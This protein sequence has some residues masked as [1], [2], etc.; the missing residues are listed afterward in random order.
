[1]RPVVEMA[2]TTFR[3]YQLRLIGT[4]NASL[5][6]AQ[7][8]SWI[9]RVVVTQSTGDTGAFIGAGATADFD[10]P[11]AAVP[12]NGFE[13]PLGGVSNV[14][15]LEPGQHLVAVGTTDPAQDPTRVS[16]S[17]SA[18]IQ[19]PKAP[20]QRRRQPA[21]FRQY[22]IE[23][24]GTGRVTRIVPIDDIPRRVIMDIPSTGST[25][26]AADANELA[27]ANAVV[28]GNSYEVRNPIVQPNRT[29]TFILAPGQALFAARQSFT[30]S[31]RVSVGEIDLTALRG[32]TGI[33]GPDSEE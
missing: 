22:L 13:L 33:P 21:T 23:I 4:P 24:L 14:F 25:F 30:T 32:P 31:L 5:R 11:G 28:P 6:V 12:G 20:I 7:A 16:V 17:V 1:M 3:T 8:A 10:L 9:Q 18:W 27:P 2:P 19:M 29:V 26:F 15:V